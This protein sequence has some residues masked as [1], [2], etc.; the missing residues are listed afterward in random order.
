MYIW[1]LLFIIM[2][3]EASQFILMIPLY[4]ETIEERSVEYRYC[5]EKNLALDY[6]EE[7]YVL[8]DD[9]GDPDHTCPLLNYLKSQPVRISFINRRQKY[10]DFFEIANREYPSRNI[11]VSNG[12]IYF[13]DTLGLLSNYDL[14]N[15]FIALTRWEDF[16][17]GRIEMHVFRPTPP[18]RAISQDVWIFKSPISIGYADIQ[19]G[20]IGC[21][22]YIAFQA[23]KS[24]LH[25]FNPCL[26]IKC[27]HV[28]NSGIRHYNKRRRFY[29]ACGKELLLTTL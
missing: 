18:L 5:L 3:C 12:D 6:I 21:D 15:E 11:I 22:P 2:S 8:Y 13:D 25:V 4:G 29:E 7:I 14:T 27:H 23:H 28:H 9:S 16:L 26:S 1:S 10:A 20:T 24:G 17:D 19:I